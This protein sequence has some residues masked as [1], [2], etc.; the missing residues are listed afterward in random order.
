M[1]SYINNHST[2][3][4]HCCINEKDES[5]EVVHIPAGDSQR[6]NNLLPTVIRCVCA[7][8]YFASSECFLTFSVLL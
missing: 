7:H 3:N 1:V 8:T 6:N 4:P 2:A 5:G